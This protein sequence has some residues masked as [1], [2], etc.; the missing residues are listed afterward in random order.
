MCVSKNRSPIKYGTPLST[1]EG[2]HFPTLQISHFSNTNLPKL[3]GKFP[4]LPP[5]VFFHA[6]PCHDTGHRLLTTPRGEGGFFFKTLKIDSPIDYGHPS[7][8][9][10]V[11]DYLLGSLVKPL[12]YDFYPTWTTELFIKEYRKN[13]RRYRKRYTQ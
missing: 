5:C 6:T 4:P 13:S 11:P 1:H 12:V 7:K 9:T 10:C 8:Y 3:L 2:F